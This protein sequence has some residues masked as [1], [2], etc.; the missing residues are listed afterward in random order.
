M[1]I[2]RKRV[3]VKDIAL[4]AGVSLGT[5]S[6]VLNHPQKVSDSTRER[7][8]T[9]IEELGFVRNDAARQLRAGSSTA[10]GLVVL[11]VGNPFFTDVAR[12]AE[13]AAS[14]SGNVVLLG[15]S[16]NDQSRERYYLA[17]FE[18]QRVRGVLVSPV[19]DASVAIDRLTGNGTPVVLIDRRADPGRYCSVSVDDVAGGALAVRHLIA[20]G[21]RRIL[22]A[23]GPSAVSQVADRLAGA[24]AAIAESP[25]DVALDVILTSEM[26]VQAGRRIGESLIARLPPE[27][28]DAVFA[29]NDL[30]A[31]GIL[32]AFESGN[33]ISVPDDIALIGYDDIDFASATA[34]PL[35]SIRQP[36]EQIGRAGVELLLDE[37]ATGDDHVHAQVLYQPELV[38]RASSMRDARVPA[39]V[40][41]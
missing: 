31:V 37:A 21:N 4:G 6:N 11:D 30:L 3:S 32:Q 33:A 12:G 41:R 24:R 7:V 28:P 34:V 29:V 16:A 39:G 13:D 35:S 2:S 1:S 9:V 25:D 15:N 22:F 27:R 38:V 20:G 40:R 36:S 17:L 18:E 10:I 14:E 5:V 23:G 26:T 19:G 8:H